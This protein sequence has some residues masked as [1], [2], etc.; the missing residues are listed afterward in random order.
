MMGN[1][2]ENAL[3]Y[4]GIVMLRA[5]HQQ[6]QMATKQGKLQLD[7]GTYRELLGKVRQSLAEVRTTE[8]ENRHRFL[9]MKTALE[10]LEANERGDPSLGGIPIFN[11][12]VESILGGPRELDFGGRPRQGQ[13]ISVNQTYRRAAAVALWEHFPQNRDQLV[14]EARTLIGIGTKKKLRKIVENFHQRHDADIARSKSPLSIHMPV[15]KDLIE[16]HRHRKL[17][18]FV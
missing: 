3:K 11:S 16:H 5:V 18:D 17:K 14:G 10:E 15:I 13:K 7:N 4:A 8:N 6:A 2:S 1:Q 12:L 9:A